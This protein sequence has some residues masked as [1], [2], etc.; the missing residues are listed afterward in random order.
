MKKSILYKKVIA[1]PSNDLIEKKVD[2]HSSICNFS[3]SQVLLE[4]KELD[5][6]NLKS[7]CF[8]NVNLTNILYLIDFYQRYLKKHKFQFD[9]NG[10]PIF[11]KSM[12]LNE[13]PDL[14]VTYKNRN[15]KIVKKKEKTLLCF[16]DKDEHLYQRFIKVFDE[17]DEY[18]KYLGVVGIDIT[19]TDD[20][21]EEWQKLTSLMNMLFMAVL[22]VNGVKVVLN[23]RSAALNPQELFSNIPKGIM[24]A[25]GFL[26][27]DKNKSKYDVR[28]ISKILCIMPAKLIIYGK[29]DEIVENQLNMMGINYR[30][31]I[32][33]HVLS[34]QKEVT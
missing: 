21:D 15:N 1:R 2:T 26:G 23:T 13:W 25:S 34:K 5:D 3:I 7:F 16:F 9:D 14:I 19:F 30:R 18:K 33:F 27:C 4:S 12:F 31:Q 17:I 22:V 11:Q 24:A 28:Y 32:D 8:K 6:K 29:K 20:M 10:Y